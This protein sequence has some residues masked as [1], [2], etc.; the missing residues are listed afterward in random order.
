[1][2]TLRLLAAL[3]GLAAPAFAA[4]GYFYGPQLSTA[5]GTAFEAL[6]GTFTV[7]G[8]SAT[9]STATIT[10]AGP[11]G[12]VTA[13]QFVGGGAGITGVVSSFIGGNGSTTTFV[14]S[15]TITA[16]LGLGITV[17]GVTAASGTFTNFVQTPLIQSQGVNGTLPLSI[18]TPSGA[19]TSPTIT[20]QPGTGNNFAGDLDL[21]GAG[22]GATYGA[23]GGVINIVGGNGSNGNGGNINLIAGSGVY[24]VPSDWG[25]IIFG[26]QGGYPFITP[27]KTYGYFDTNGSLNLALPL[28]ANGGVNIAEALNIGTNTF[29]A[30]TAIISTLT[31]NTINAQQIIWGDQTIS[32]S[33]GSGSA[34]NAGLVLTSTNNVLT[35]G[36]TFSPTSTVTIQGYSNVE[37]FLS[38]GSTGGSSLTFGIP[39]PVNSTVKCEFT[40]TQ[41]S[42]TSGRPQLTFNSDS[43]AYYGYAI[44]S[45]SGGGSGGTTKTWAT[46]NY[47]PLTFLNVAITYM[48]QVTADFSFKQQA[49]LT[50]VTRSFTGNTTSGYSEETAGGGSW[51]S[52]GSILPIYGTITASAGTMAASIRCTYIAY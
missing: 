36:N 20:I 29:T 18:V 32:T 11:T 9:L 51:Y 16:P 2:K 12:T 43:G 3:L 35:A 23:N 39:A 30:G 7:A 26:A 24:D 41:W 17:G 27:Y 34:G 19:N 21:Y 44:Q 15:V 42:T 46:A 48:G 45:F 4:Q 22:G 10:L 8:S 38:S 6:A 31:A 40:V 14:S 47:I 28:Y 52:Q 25:E 49:L 13:S 33:A 50:M 1:M 5:T 37:T